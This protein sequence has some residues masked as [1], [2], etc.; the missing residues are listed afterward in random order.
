MKDMAVWREEKGGNSEKNQES[1]R[2]GEELVLEDP[3]T[4]LI[5]LGSI[6]KLFSSS[7]FCMLHPA[8]QSTETTSMNL[9][10]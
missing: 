3:H 7:T 10:T 4:V 1:V 5:I 6:A 2:K 9:E 8:W